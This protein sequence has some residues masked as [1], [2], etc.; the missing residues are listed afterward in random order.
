M[1]VLPRAQRAQIK[2]SRL[3][4][5]AYDGIPNIDLKTIYL[6]KLGES[7]YVPIDILNK[8]EIIDPLY[9]NDAKITLIKLKLTEF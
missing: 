6:G 5:N 4:I 7:H 8:D 1:C 2:R 3:T 9:Y